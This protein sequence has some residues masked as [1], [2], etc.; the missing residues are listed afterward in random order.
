[1]T[2][3]FL[4]STIAVLM[5]GGLLWGGL[6]TPAQG[7]T[8]T[9]M[10]RYS[11]H[12]PASGGPVA[13]RAGA[14]L[15]AGIA[16][17][18]ALF[19]NPAGLGW[20]S[21]SA[22]SGDFA[23]NRTQSDTRFLTPDATASADRTVSNYRLG[24]LGGAY[25]FPTTQGSLVIGVSFHQSN[26]YD[27]GFDVAAANRTNSITGTLLPTSNGY[28]VDG[29][30]LIFDS[31]RSRIAYEAG[32]IDFSR[33]V[34][35]NGNYPFFQGANPQASATNGQMTL[36]Q[37]ENLTESGQMNELSF[38]LAT[39]IAPNVMLG[40]GLNVAFG[41]YTFERLYRETEVS[42]L[43]PPEN[44]ENPQPPYDPYFLAGTSIEGFRQ[45]QLEDRIEADLSGVNFRFGLSA[46][47]TDALRVGVHVESPTW[48]TVNEVYGT[49]MQ[50]QFDCDFDLNTPCPQG[51]VEG[52][53]SGNLTGN[54]FS[55]DI[56]TPWRVGGG[57]QFSMAELTLAGGA[58]LIDWAQAEIS[59]DDASFTTLNRD[60]EDL[61][62]TINTRVG[63]EY[64][65]DAFAL[66]T[67][68]AYQP[69][70]TDRSF[71]D[72]DGN[73]VDG[74]QLFL[75]AGT[76]VSI[77]ENATLHL[78]WMQERFDDRYLSYTTDGPFSSG[79]PPTVREAIHRN[80]FLIGLTYRP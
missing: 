21:S 79:D 24:S 33:S 51:G 35:D 58:T 27:R 31:R 59:A 60:L 53:S 52:F 3:S 67:G 55:Y 32:V 57:L 20:M 65:S 22:I 78:S 56:R 25:S 77:S 38:G 64:S 44:P 68:V 42:D 80:R 54:E 45:M 17:S 4:F 71:Q 16:A 13:G 74:D 23:I 8:L 6:S 73:T 63:L 9:D 34:Y 11:Q 41:S 47:P 61:D 15:S 50:T 76:S 39:A 66:R 43:L 2:R 29:E 26:T 48:L 1:M 30:D 69:S 28:E 40:G 5:L 14:G 18:D 46:E 75:S 19:G 37:Q 10:I 12:L 36:E 49:E 70:P 62:A 7:Q 72:I